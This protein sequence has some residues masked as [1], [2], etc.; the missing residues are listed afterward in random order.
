MRLLALAILYTALATGANADTMINRDALEALR[1]GDMRKLN[2][3]AEPERGSE[4][5]FIDENDVELSLA[6]LEGKYLLVN[7]W[8]TW[9]A[10]CRHEMPQLSNLQAELGS[11]TFEVVT[12][13]TG[14]NPVPAMQMFF[15]EIEVDNLPL[16]RDPRQALARDMGV[17]GLPITILLNPEGQE[18]ARLR[19]DA[20]WDSDS[21]MAIIS[22]LTA[23]E[24]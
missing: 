17:L 22:A 12:I 1:E 15:N 8:A 2:F 19:G 14:R 5:T 7:F 20:E 11:D 9:C 21:A 18:I 6:D 4:V 23:P 10:P 3:H 16:Y 13:A 24:S